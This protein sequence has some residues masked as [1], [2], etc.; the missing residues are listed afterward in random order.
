LHKPVKLVNMETGTRLAATQVLMDG[1]RARVSLR[2]M[3]TSIRKDEKSSSSREK[4][5]ILKGNSRVN[6]ELREGGEA[7]R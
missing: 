6:E 5:G 7:V 4:K 2:V 1:N 3:I